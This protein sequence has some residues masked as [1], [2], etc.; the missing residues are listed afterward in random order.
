MKVWTW[1]ATILL[2]GASPLEAASTAPQGTEPA[3]EPSKE[4]KKA[5][6]AEKN[7][8]AD[9]NDDGGAQKGMAKKSAWTR[10][11]RGRLAKLDRAAGKIAVVM[12]GET[13]ELRFTKETMVRSGGHRL[14]MTDLE[15]GMPVTVYC[16]R[17]GPQDVATLVR[18]ERRPPVN[19]K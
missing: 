11:A 9:P 4:A 7:K 1:I 3:K 8:G 13:S 12:G 17:E 14:S 19:P 16:A 5:A 10:C 6:P 2:L 18:I 15:E